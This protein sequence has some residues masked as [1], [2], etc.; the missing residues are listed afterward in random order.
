MILIYY[1]NRAEKSILDPIK[2]ELDRRGIKNRYF[3]LSK[4]IEN[5]SE[6]KNLSKVY[7]L[8]FSRV[9]NFENINCVIVIGD[10]REIMFATLALF[11]KQVPVIQL[12]AGD[13]SEKISLVDDYFRHLI[14][15]MSKKQVCFTRKSKIN[16]DSLI[17]TLNLESN[18]IFLENPTLS[19]VCLERVLAPDRRESYDLI[20]V[21]PQSLSKKDTQEDV[22]SIK[23]LINLNK[24]T[25]IIK[26]NKDKNY[27]VLHEY[28]KSLEDKKNVYVY[29]NLEKEIFLKK[30]ANC[31]RFITNSSC[32]YYEAPLFLEE[33][34]ILRIGN[35]NKHREVAKYNIKDMK[36]SNKIVDFIIKG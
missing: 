30:L 28:W 4:L 20:L 35:R 15:L 21:H 24:K 3:D 26:G 32:S 11:V 2:S 27:E 9:D 34:K 5:I 29:E 19:D 31:D 33:N 25:I 1:A 16:S 7:D 17:N 12:A 36:S 10:R 6:D 13:L 22:K 18:S 14:T 8:V 23:K